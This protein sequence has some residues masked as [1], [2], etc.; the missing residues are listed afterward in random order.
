MKYS[1]KYISVIIFTALIAIGCDVANVDDK[2]EML[3]KDLIIYT[4]DKNGP[5]DIY[6]AH[7]DGSGEVRLTNNDFAE[8]SPTISPDGKTI[9][10]IRESQVWTMNFD[11]SKA[12]ALYAEGESTSVGYS[13]N[14]DQLII[15]QLN[16]I[17]VINKDGTAPK[18]HII[19]DVANRDVNAKMHP[20]G[21]LILY[22][23]PTGKG[24][25]IF[26]LN[27]ET[28]E[29]T[30]LTDNDVDD[31]DATWSPNG[32]EIL[33][34]SID[35]VGAQN[36]FT[37]TVSGESITQ[38]TTFAAGTIDNEVNPCWANESEIYL[39]TIS[40]QGREIKSKAATSHNASRSNRSNGIMSD[41]VTDGDVKGVSCSQ[42]VTV[43][44]KSAY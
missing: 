29:T 12:S 16:S 31:S 23:A 25:E 37:M 7:K 11:G 39:T 43:K 40:T 41:I 8:S 18:A 24:S 22:T 2:P 3:E 10:F 4:S 42:K 38:E 26:L 6:I 27:W 5:V 44:L 32:S 28:K 1:I 20:A 14:G 35:A 34:V 33:F 19:S 9:A 21:N 17:V 15:S 13:P 30:Q 36:L